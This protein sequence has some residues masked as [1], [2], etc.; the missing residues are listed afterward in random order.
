DAVRA[1]YLAD[2]VSALKGIR[3]VDRTV[4][5]IV[6]ANHFPPRAIVLGDKCV[7]FRAEKS[8]FHAG[9][10][11]YQERAFYKLWQNCGKSGGLESEE[12]FSRWKSLI[13][14]VVILLWFMS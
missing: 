7:P 11:S 5:N 14:V 3:K 12:S 1:G 10:F 8:I 9:S 6:T 4:R 13:I 2:D